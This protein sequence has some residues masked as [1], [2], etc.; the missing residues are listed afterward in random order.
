MLGIVTLKY[1]TEVAGRDTYFVASIKAFYSNQ[2]NT[3]PR[4][5]H[6]KGFPMKIKPITV[7]LTILMIFV[8]EVAAEAACRSIRLTCPDDRS[9]SQPTRWDG[10]TLRC[11]SVGSL[12]R[13][14]RPPSGV[15]QRD[16]NRWWYPVAR[17]RYACSGPVGR[18]YVWETGFSVSPERLRTA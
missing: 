7:V 12:E 3:H 4:K 16:L 1:P 10:R 5:S 9:F 15:S 2:K 11:V 6:K 13:R 14:C 8:G 18:S 17:Q